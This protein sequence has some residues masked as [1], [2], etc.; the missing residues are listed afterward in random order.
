MQENEVN[1]KF[2]GLI[3]YDLTLLRVYFMLQ[4]T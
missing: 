3:L 4:I 2:N 1:N